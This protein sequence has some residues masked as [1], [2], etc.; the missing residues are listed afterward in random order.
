MTKGNWIVNGL[1]GLALMGGGGWLVYAEVSKPP[2]H[3]A[4][5]YVAVGIALLGALLINPTPIISSVKQVVVIVLPLVPWG[6]PLA[7]RLS[8]QTQAVKDEDKTP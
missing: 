1:M 3:S 4:H 8:G 6:K 7:A 2:M 5:L